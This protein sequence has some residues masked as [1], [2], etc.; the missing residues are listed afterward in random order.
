MVQQASQLDLLPRFRVI[1]TS[2]SECGQIYLPGGVNLLLAVA[3]TTLVITF[4]S[5]EKLASVYGIAVTLTMSMTFALLLL[6][7]HLRGRLF[8]V[9]GLT[10]AA[11]LIVMPGLFIANL[12]TVSS[13][14]WI[15]LGVA[16]ALVAVMITWRRADRQVTAAR[17]QAEPEI[18][19]ILDRLDAAPRVP[20]TSVYLTAHPGSLPASFTTMLDR[21]RN[22]SDRV[23]L[24]SVRIA[25]M[26]TGAPRRSMGSLRGLRLSMWSSV[27][28]SRCGFLMRF[29]QPRTA[30][31]APSLWRRWRRVPSYSP[32]KPL[33]RAADH[34]CPIG[35]NGSL[36]P[37]NVGSSPGLRMPSCHPARR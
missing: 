12:V 35:S 31:A 8:S 13:G 23:I 1:H 18:A 30:P 25:G 11:M 3:V 15:P 5:S 2:A 24:M 17:R 20:G 10:V 37:S 32:L 4:R 33:C 29:F 28:G 7:L 22:L 14:G 34:L 16:A 26:P 19:D 9:L 6:L 36:S 27:T 21:Y